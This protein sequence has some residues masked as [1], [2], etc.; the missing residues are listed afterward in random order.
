MS[1]KIIDAVATAPAATQSIS[2]PIKME[3]GAAMAQMLQQMAAAQQQ[4]TTQTVNPAE[5]LK[6]AVTRME[7]I[8]SRYSRLLTLGKQLNG[9]NKT[10]RLPDNVAIENVAITFRLNGEAPIT[11]DVKNIVCVGDLSTILSAEMGIMILELQQLNASILDVG[12]RAEEQYAK[13]RKHWEESNKDR[14]IVI[15]GE[16]AP[17]N[18]KSAV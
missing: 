18:E 17:Q 5:H 10:D 8:Y 13:S 1:E 12:K 15:A 6:A 14:Q 16:E 3:G 11:A 7:E 2:V 4:P 9:L